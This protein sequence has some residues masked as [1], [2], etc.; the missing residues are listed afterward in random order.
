MGLFAHY[1]YLGCNS[2]STSDKIWLHRIEAHNELLH[3]QEKGFLVPKPLVIYS[4]DFNCIG[5]LMAF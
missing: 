5:H 1:G 4:D 2:N 3:G